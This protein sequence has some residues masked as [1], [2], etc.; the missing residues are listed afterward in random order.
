MQLP[1]LGFDPFF[2]GEGIRARVLHALTDEPQSG[3]QLAGYLHGLT[4]KQIADALNALYLMER[5]T[6]I[7]RKSGATWRRQTREEADEAERRRVRGRG[8]DW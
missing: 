7:G 1:D 5:V 6:R 8:G 2:E 4:R 3:R